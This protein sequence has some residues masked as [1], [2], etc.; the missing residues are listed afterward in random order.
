MPSDDKVKYCAVYSP[1][2][3][4]HLLVASV[5]GHVTIYDSETRSQVA[6]YYLDQNTYAPLDL[7]VSPDGRE[8]LVSTWRN[9][10]FTCNILED[11]INRNYFRSHQLMDTN[12]K[13]GAFS[14]CFSNDATEI[15]ASSND[16]CIY[17][18]D[19]T[20]DERSQ[21][22]VQDLR[23]DINAV[24]FL[25]PAS[26]NVIVGGSDNGIIEIW[27]RRVLGTYAKTRKSVATLVGHHDGITYI[28][29]KGDG[30]YFISNSK[31]QAL[32]LWDVRKVGRP[33]QVKKTRKLLAQ[34]AT[35]NYH[36]DTIPEECKY[37]VVILCFVDPCSNPEISQITAQRNHWTETAV[38]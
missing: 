16:G 9:N 37:K 33:H 31:D 5:D 35:W 23:G 27:D 1:D 28:D 26:N 14:A 17:L 13:M 25:D 8:F 21:R 36:N 2:N 34:P 15:L 12:N 24:R 11:D 20:R 18:Y 6:R 10:V 22:I 7:D 4:R 32:K 19:R 38:S 3:G 30:R 29:A